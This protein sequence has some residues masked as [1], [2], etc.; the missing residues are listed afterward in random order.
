MKSGAAMALG[1]ND[2]GSKLMDASRKASE[3]S[4][5]V[6]SVFDKGSV[7]SA[8]PSNKSAAQKLDKY[9]S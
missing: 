9:I 6:K 7:K 8:H 5:A 4:E 2:A 1:S 3:A